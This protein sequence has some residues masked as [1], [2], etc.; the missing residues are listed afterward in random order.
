MQV[1]REKKEPKKKKKKNKLGPRSKTAPADVETEQGEKKSTEKG[2]VVSGGK[3]KNGKSAKLK[4]SLK[5]SAT[6]D[7]GD[8]ID[9]SKPPHHG[10]VYD[11]TLNKEG[12]RRCFDSLMSL[13]SSS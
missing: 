11:I 13:G 8:G 4:S 2:A 3:M 1:V 10:P 5:K 7:N 6:Q 12:V 9:F